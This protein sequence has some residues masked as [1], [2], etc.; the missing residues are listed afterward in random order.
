MTAIKPNKN[1]LFSNKLLVLFC[2]PLFLGIVWLVALYNQTVNIGH[3]IE[4][5]N[6]DLKKL[7][8]ET[9]ELQDTM[10]NSFSGERIEAFAKENRLIK[11]KTP[12]YL[13]INDQ[14][15]FALQQ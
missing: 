11:E 13:E 3:G 6:A 14:W 4:E 2:A 10:F 8:G 12:E 5:M 1:K 9:A 15:A 7:Q